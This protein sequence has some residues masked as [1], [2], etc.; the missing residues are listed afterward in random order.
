METQKIKA[1]LLAAEKKSLSAAAEELSY[2][3]SA[4]SHMADALEEELGVK[5]LERTRIGV[6]L[7][8]AGEKLKE[9]L[10]SVITA[11]NELKRAAA[12][13]TKHADCELRIAAYSSISTYLLPEI[14]QAFKQK[15]PEIKVS[16][17]VD[18]YLRDLLQKGDAD[19]VFGDA[20]ILGDN[21]KIMLMEDDYV[22]LL[23]EG[24]FGKRRSVNREELY[25]FAF[26]KTNESFI[27]K[28]FDEDRFSEIVNLVSIDNGSVIS[29][30]K[31]K[32][33]V[34]VLPSL[35]IRK[36]TKGIKALKLVPKVSRSL[37]LAYKSGSPAIE[38]FIDF[39]KNDYLK[40]Q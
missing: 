24:T 34:A 6:E 39:I 33:G 1:I 2:T 38:K 25:D 8:E 27:K 21:E 36:G 9:K 32:L 5:I 20:A 35:S 23:P 19:V 14:L 7:S 12:E 22:A 15:Y 26:I 30:V 3:P 28:Y 13:I 37:G 29:M 31:K 40:K 16:I 10:T 17:S 11:E 4:M 18:D